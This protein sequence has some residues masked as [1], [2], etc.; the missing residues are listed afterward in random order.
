MKNNTK[1]NLL[2]NISTNLRKFLGQKLHGSASDL[3]RESYIGQHLTTDNIFYEHYLPISRF[4]HKTHKA[5]E[6]AYTNHI[7]PFFGDQ[8]I[9]KIQLSEVRRWKNN[10]LAK[11]LSASTINKLII[12]FG[13]LIDLAKGLEIKGVPSRTKL[14]LELLKIPDNQDFFLSNEQLISL[15]KE[16]RR[17]NN[18]N[19]LHIV[20]LLVLTGARKREILDAKWQDMDFNL[21]LL[22]VPCSKNGKPRFITLCDQA[23]RLICELHVLNADNEYIV[24]NPKTGKPYRCIYHAWDK[25]RKAANLPNVRIHDLRHSFASALVNSGI[26]LY[27]VQELLGHSSIKTTQRYA[28]LDQSRLQKSVEHI[29]TFYDC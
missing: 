16:C 23:Y 27:E 17:S 1:H 28:H 10:L 4:K 12:I 5:R 19:L 22:R 15:R 6:G 13:Q 25:A 2:L 29:S 9:V 3:F 11:G 26:S 8:R 18:L 24:T 21:K 14:G 7:Q 20:D